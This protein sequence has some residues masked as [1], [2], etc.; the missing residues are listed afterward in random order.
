VVEHGGNLCIN[1]GHIT[2]GGIPVIM[3]QRLHNICQ[4]IKVNG[5]SIYNTTVWEKR[6]QSK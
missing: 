3:Q 4:W 5:E 1:A 6:Q 2:D